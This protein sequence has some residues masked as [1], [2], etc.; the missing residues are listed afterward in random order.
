M[1]DP[2]GSAHY[3]RYEI[4]ISCARKNTDD[5]LIKLGKQIKSLTEGLFPDR[6][7]DND[8]EVEIIEHSGKCEN[9]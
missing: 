1:N 7:F 8:I 5:Y 4:V 6:M 3:V 9:E 2:R